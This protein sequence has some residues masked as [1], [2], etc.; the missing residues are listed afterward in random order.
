MEAREA[1]YYCHICACDVASKVNTSNSEIECNICSSN[2]IEL[3][4]Q[5]VENFVTGDSIPP[6]RNVNNTDR[7]SRR[8]ERSRSEPRQPLRGREI[9][10]TDEQEL[11][12]R[13][14]QDIVNGTDGSTQGIFV[15]SGVNLSHNHHYANTRIMPS[16]YLRGAEFGGLMSSFMMMRALPGDVT[17]GFLGHV[18]GN[19]RTFEDLLHHLFMSDSSHAG[20]PPATERIIESLKR[21]VVTSETDL[22]VLGECSISQEAFELG[23]T[24]VHLPC[25]HS[26]KQEPIIHWLKMHNTCPVCRIPLTVDG[27]DNNIKASEI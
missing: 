10:V 21:S 7:D 15:S 5:G 2:F 23:D 11:T 3:L 26:Y 22:A 14:L 6:C 4:G 25:K 24:A 18:G 1:D 27:D 12:N 16:P 19:G 20:E 8:R 13:D 17:G 9:A